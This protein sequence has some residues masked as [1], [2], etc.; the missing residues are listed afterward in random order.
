[1]PN[2]APD[3]STARALTGSE[4]EPAQAVAAESRE[5]LHE[6]YFGHAHVTVI[7]PARPF[8]LIDLREL[9]AYRELLA[10]LAR[11]QISVRYKQTILGAGWAIIQPLMQMVVFTVLFGKMANMPSEGVPYPVFLYSALLPWTYFTSATTSSVGS[12]VANAH[13]ISKVYFPRLIIPLA[14]VL[15]ALIDLIVASIALLALMLWYHIAVTP[16]LLL[17][18][19]LVLGIMLAAT[20][21]GAGLGAL[22]VKYRDLGYVMPFLMQLWLYATPVLYP[23][24]LVPPAWR[25]IVKLNPLTGLI[26]GFRDVVLGRALDPVAIAA[27]LSVAALLFVA[28]TLYFH[29]TER[30]FA[31]IV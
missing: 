25:F 27:S 14:S 23:A 20:G 11:R 30:R 21:I 31:D 19:V 17:V 26:T 4:P 3:S 6:H 10:T 29:A 18:P 15:A 16:Q 7:G 24:H 1:M 22:N 5:S 9:W 8:E 13:L 2:D 12:L 28:G